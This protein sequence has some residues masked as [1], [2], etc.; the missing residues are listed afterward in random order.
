MAY[1]SF[2]SFFEILKKILFKMLPEKGYVEFE[3]LPKRGSLNVSLYLT[4]IIKYSKPWRITVRMRVLSQCNRTKEPES[5]LRKE[6]IIFGK[7]IQSSV[8]GKNSPN[9]NWGN[10]IH[11]M[12]TKSIGYF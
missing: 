1:K 6:L 5:S 8:T 3:H 4:Q 2:E 7:Y 10:D 11:Y 12:K 9:G